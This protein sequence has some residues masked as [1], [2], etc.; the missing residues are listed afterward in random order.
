M[1]HALWHLMQNTI[2]EEHPREDAW[3]TGNKK[4]FIARHMK[5]MS[6]LHDMLDHDLS[7][8]SQGEEGK[9]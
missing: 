8:V 9:T 5:A 1:R 3:Y 6:L 2:H 4:T 7:V